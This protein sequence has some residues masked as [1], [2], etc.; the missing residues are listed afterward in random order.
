MAFITSSLFDT[1]FYDLNERNVWKVAELKGFEKQLEMLLAWNE[2]S[3]GFYFFYIRRSAKWIILNI[4][5]AHLLVEF[6]L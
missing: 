6:C 2:T 3:R 4:K 5:Y 1:A